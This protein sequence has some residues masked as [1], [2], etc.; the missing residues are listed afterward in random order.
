MI[1][2]HTS[3][4]TDARL[5]TVSALTRRSLRHIE[6]Q[7]NNSVK[8][9]NLPTNIQ[10]TKQTGESDEAARANA[11]MSKAIKEAMEIQGNGGKKEGDRG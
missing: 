7:T 9:H 1:H 11:K 10:C 3:L 4:L 2:Y 6:T 8:S 5:F